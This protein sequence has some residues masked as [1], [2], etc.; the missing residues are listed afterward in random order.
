MRQKPISFTLNDKTIYTPSDIDKVLTLSVNDACWKGK[1]NGIYYLN[2]SC[3]FD[4]ETTSFYRDKNGVAYNYNDYMA[5]LRNNPK[6]KL[7][8]CAIMYV[9]QFGINGRVIIGRT[10][11]EFLKMMLRIS[12]VLD[13]SDNR[14][15]IIYVH[16]LSFEFQYIRKLFS[17]SKV[18]ATD[19]RK[20]IYALTNRGIEFRCSYML[21]G[22][23]LAKLGNQLHTYK[24]EKMVGDL[25][26]S[27]LRH[28]QTVLT[29]KELRYC[30]NDVLVVMAYI[31]ELLDKQRITLLPITKTGFVRKLCRKNCLNVRVNG[32]QQRNWGYIDKMKEQT[33]HG[34]EEYRDLKRAFSGGF[35]HAAAQYAGLTLEN[36]ASYDFTSSYPYVM[37]S[38]MF[39]TSHGVF[40]QIKS[41]QEFFKYMSKYLCIFTCAFEKIMESRCYD[42]PISVSKCRNVKGAVNNNGRLVC[43]EYIETTLT[44]IDYDYIKH[45]YTWQRMQ[46]CSMWCY[47]KGYLPT[48]FVKTILDL[49]KKKTTLKGV[50]GSEFEYLQSKELLNSCYGMCVTDIVRP[51]NEYTD[52]EGWRCEEIDDIDIFNDQIFQYNIK[53]N[54]F[55]SYVWGVFVTAYARRNLFT[56]ITEFGNDYVYS[57]TDSVKVLNYEKHAQYI[58]AYNRNCKLKLISACKHHNIDYD[59]CAP[60]TVKGVIKPLG[61]WD[62][63]GV[64]SR[65][66][67]LGAKRYMIEKD[68]EINIT[69]AGVNKHTA[70]PYLLK[71]Y[72]KDIFTAFDNNLYIPAGACGKKLHTYIDYPIRG[73]ITDYQGINANYSEQSG[74][75]LEET[76]Y[77]LNMGVAYMKYINGIRIKTNY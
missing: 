11:S 24:V 75:H 31:Q 13:L 23:P 22:Y 54:R 34:I 60:Q 43:A 62:F 7:S 53:K 25:D 69:V 76:D 41:K 27:L 61:V 74:V 46:V 33:I 15:L 30:V 16:N 10:W 4:I 47:K 72:G 73:C 45:Y 49:Y 21:S 70:V 9:W 44:N 65:F 6:S 64:Y 68:G 66:K 29:E 77:S 5:I 58:N 67:T 51:L 57:D 8:K 26:Y 36:V 28:S 42:N 56:G 17:W 55:L 63:E 40:V 18:F 19:E 3:A 71:T 37:V 14:I 39:P 50:A 48:E 2:I 1:N 12:E 35:T 59:M 38:E 20:P 52:N 32:K